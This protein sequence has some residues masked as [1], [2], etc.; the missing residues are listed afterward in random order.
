MLYEESGLKVLSG[1]TNDVAALVASDDPR[2]AF[3]L[4]CFTYRVAQYVGA[5]A[6]AMG[7]IDAVVFTGGIGENAPGLRGAVLERLAFL[8][9]VESLV[10]PANEERMMAIHARELLETRL[11]LMP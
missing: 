6:V 11:E 2:A 9:P 4:D 5:M 10:I 1:L 8:G 7:G 3:A